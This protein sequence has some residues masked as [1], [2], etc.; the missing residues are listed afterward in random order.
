MAD[1]FSEFW[2]LSVLD[3][4]F[5]LINEYYEGGRKRE[6]QKEKSFF[7]RFPPLFIYYLSTSY[8]PHL[9]VYIYTRKCWPGDMF[10]LSQ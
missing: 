4:F 1:C 8:R 7:L 10:I 5:P 6:T 3:I 2:R 9:R